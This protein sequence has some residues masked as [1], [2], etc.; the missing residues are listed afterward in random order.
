MGEAQQV[1]RI[2]ISFVTSLAI[3]YII[4]K[5]IGEERKAQWF[6]KRTKSN[7]FTR[8]GFLGD[9]WN[10]GVPYR[11]Q[12][13]MVVFFMFGIIGLVSYAVIFTN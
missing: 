1:T 3:I 13:F 12:G 10:F 6:K 11:W 8:R 9:T 2:I 5:I 7:I 4:A